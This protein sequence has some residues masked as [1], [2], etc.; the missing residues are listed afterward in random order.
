MTFE[1]KQI[2]LLKKLRD[3]EAFD[4]LNNM[5]F[6]DFLIMLNDEDVIPNTDFPTILQILEK[7][8][9]INEYKPTEQIFITGKGLEYLENKEKDKRIVWTTR[10]I[11]FG[12]V[13]TGIYYTFCLVKEIVQMF[14]CHHQ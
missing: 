1:E 10:A 6:D 13:L 5:P 8:K 3:N 7:R 9:L 11:I 4:P 12:A 2:Y 14:F